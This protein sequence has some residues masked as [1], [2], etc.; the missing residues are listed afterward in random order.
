MHC[1]SAEAGHRM[2]CRVRPTDLPLKSW[3]L[4]GDLQCALHLPWNASPHGNTNE[5]QQSWGWR[6]Q[7]CLGYPWSTPRA[8]RKCSAQHNALWISLIQSSSWH[9][10]SP[11]AY[12]VPWHTPGQHCLL[13]VLRTFTILI[14]HC[15]GRVLQIP[16]VILLSLKWTS[17]GVY[18]TVDL[19][20]E[21]FIKCYT[22]QYFLNRFDD[23]A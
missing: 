4:T 16:S 18:I 17:P 3:F 10:L 15:G 20:E 6:Q 11:C 14:L 13:Q 1:S 9:R 12:T 7:F 21:L 8:Q 22:L 19:N 23:Y 5:R 2:Q